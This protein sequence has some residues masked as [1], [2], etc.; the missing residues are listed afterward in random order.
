[1]HVRVSISAGIFLGWGWWRW[2][3]EWRLGVHRVQGII[4]PN[5]ESKI[6]SRP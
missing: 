3:G 1:M 5:T 6:Q 2:G 4:S